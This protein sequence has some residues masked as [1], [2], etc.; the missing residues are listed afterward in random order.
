MLNKSPFNTQQSIQ[1]FAVIFFAMTF[2]IR[3]GNGFGALGLFLVTLISIPSLYQYYK[4]HALTG[5]EKG[6]FF[7]LIF[8][9]LIPMLSA[10]NEGLSGSAYDKPARYLVAAMTFILLLRYKVNLMSIALGAW[11][12]AIFA[13]S[14]ALYDVFYLDMPRAGGRFTVVI[15]F[16][17]ISLLLTGFVMFCYQTLKQKIP[18]AFIVLSI[19]L[20][21]TA[22]I[23]SQTRG[24]WL[25]IPFLLLLVISH[26]RYSLVNLNKKKCVIITTLLVSI[27]AICTFSAGEMISERIKEVQ[28]DI[29][30]YQK[31]D[32][33]TPVGLRFD[34]WKGG[35]QSIKNNP[36][37]GGGEQGVVIAKQQLDA[38]NKI[39]LPTEAI[40][41][42]SVHNQ[43]LD[44]W[45]K[46]GVFAFI[47]LLGLFLIPLVFFI[48]QRNKNDK[49]ARTASYCGISLCMGY[50][51]FGLT[52][53]IFTINSTVMFYSFAIII[54]FSSAKTAK[55]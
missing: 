40:N 8:F 18:Q 51:F 47:A 46:Y 5:F 17:D 22:V 26:Y 45:A 28:S 12:G 16:G 21:F 41:W 36:I 15:E 4:S 30:L 53:S 13:G 3:S 24:A 31:G 33:F 11:L 37:L 10:F 1:F 50:L 19:L 27:I 38:E 32:S 48:K 44:T 14:N 20:G 54:L 23:L 43:Y 9:A 55:V 6:L 42:K 35:I 25:F 52:E 39:N 49:E 34:M 29:T 2:L 7:G